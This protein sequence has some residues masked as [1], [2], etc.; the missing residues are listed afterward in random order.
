MNPEHLSRQ[1]LPPRAGVGVVDVVRDAGWLHTAGGTAPYVALFARVP[2]LHRQQVDDAVYR[3]FELIEVPCVRDSMMLVPRDDLGIA[4]AAGRR[5]YDARLKMIGKATGATRDEIAR[6]AERI[7]KTLGDGIRSAD[8]LHKE[9][10]P[11]L[12]RDFGEAGRKLGVTSTL[13][14][15]LKLLQVEGRIVRVG[16]N[17]RIDAKLWFYRRAPSD[18]PPP[19]D[20]LDAALAARFLRWAAPAATEEFAWWAGIGKRAA[21]AAL[22]RASVDPPPP[23]APESAPILLPFRDNLFVLRHD[24]AMHHNAIVLR[25]ERR[26]VWEWDVERE[27]IAWRLFD[28]KRAAGVEREC[29]RVATFIRQELGDHRIY[30]LDHARSRAERLAF[31]R[32]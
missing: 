21:Q 32:G 25:G 7:E 19:P 29:A 8:A 12:I 1:L 30:A 6:L 2:N 9:V 3:R 26:G 4:L 28:G 15:A 20:D 27:E 14:L 23:V 18:A 10:P 5:S 13:P 22:D 31:V 16:E 24:E 11:R 17:H